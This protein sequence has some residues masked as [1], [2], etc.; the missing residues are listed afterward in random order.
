[1][2]RPRVLLA[3][4]VLPLVAACGPGEIDGELEPYLVK[5]REQLEQ[6]RAQLHAR[7]GRPLGPDWGARDG[8]TCYFDNEADKLYWRQ[9]ETVV[10]VADVSLVGTFEFD[11]KAPTDKPDEAG[12]FKWSWFNDKAGQ[13]SRERMQA[14]RRWGQAR[15]SVKLSTGGWIGHPHWAVDML[16]ASVRVLGASGGYTLEVGPTLL[17]FILHSLREPDEAERKITTQGK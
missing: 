9:G 1:M 17:L 6:S 13:G 16:A 4:V 3:S 5:A 10:L 14:V 11:P 15:R 2:M 7:W 12:S 8:E